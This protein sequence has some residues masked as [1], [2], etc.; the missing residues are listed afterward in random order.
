MI[1]FIDKGIIRIINIMMMYITLIL[2]M[3]L[4]NIKLYIKGKRIAKEW[5]YVLL[6]IRTSN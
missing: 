3:S 4:I 2:K 6:I 1:K 5:D